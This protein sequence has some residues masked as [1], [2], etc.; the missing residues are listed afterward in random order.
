[1]KPIGLRGEFLRLVRRRISGCSAMD[2]SASFSACS[3]TGGAGRLGAQQELGRIG[4]KPRLGLARGRP[5]AEAAVEALAVE[6]RA[7]AACSRAARLL[8]RDRPVGQQRQREAAADRLLQAAQRI[9]L[10]RPHQPGDVVADRAAE[11]RRSRARCPAGSG[12]R[13]GASGASA[14]GASSAPATTVTG[15]R[16]GRTVIAVS[17]VRVKPGR[18]GDVQADHAAAGAGGAQRRRRHRLRARSRAWPR[19]APG[20]PARAGPRPRESAAASP[21]GR[22]RLC[23]STASRASSPG[24]RKRGSSGSATSGSR[25]SDVGLRRAD[26]GCRS[27]RPPSGATAGEI[28]Q[29]ERD[30]CAVPSGAGLHRRRRTASRSAA[31]CRAARSCPR[32]RPGAAGV[33]SPSGRRDQPA[34]IVADVECRAVAGRGNAP[35]GSGEAKLVSR[36]MPSSTAAR[37]IQAPGAARTGTDGLRARRILSGAVDRAPS[38]LRRGR[39]RRRPR[40][41]RSPGWAGWSRHRQRRGRRDGDIGA[42]APGGVDRDLDLGAALGDAKASRNEMHPVGQHQEASPRRAKG[43][44][45]WMRAVSPGR[46]DARGRRRRRPGPARP[47]SRDA[48][49]PARKRTEVA[50]RPFGFGDLQPVAAEIAAFG[51]SAAGSPAGMAIV[52]RLQRLVAPDRLV[53]GQAAAHDDPPVGPL[54]HQPQ[55][56]AAAPIRAPSGDDRGDL[57]RRF[58]AGVDGAIGEQRLDRR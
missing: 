23:S 1:M 26:R 28:G 4:G 48:T 41:G 44:A 39:D 57:E 19:A 22:S 45:M 34:P 40:R 3:G 2:F 6:H 53:A 5:E 16:A 46:V 24:A 36:R 49:Q 38:S 29:V 35:T 58:R 54:A 9:A 7:T 13:A 47:G 55:P 32:R 14:P 52:L 10:Q 12:R 37:V 20:R 33:A 18:P 8:A 51:R 43:G 56:R 15:P 11:A 17:R 50:A 21:A 30:P 27:R 25:T 42:R 31:G